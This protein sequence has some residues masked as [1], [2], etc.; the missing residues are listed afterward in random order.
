MLKFLQITAIV[1]LFGLLGGLIL[2]T[3]ATGAQM[4]GKPVT[5]MSPVEGRGLIEEFYELGMKP[6]LGFVGYS[7]TEWAQKYPSSFYI[8]HT[9]GPPTRT[10]IMEILASGNVCVLT[11]NTGNPVE[12]NPDELDKLLRGS[13]EES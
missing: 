10:A 5:C 4:F 13:G 6:L 8:M 3:S 9:A 12:F 1:L 7:Q 11:G 2:T